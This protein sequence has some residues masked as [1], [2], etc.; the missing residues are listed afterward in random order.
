MM[1]LFVFL[2]W[3]DPALKSLTEY[4][5]LPWW[6]GDNVKLAFWRPLTSLT[7]WMDYQLWPDSPM[8]MRLQN[9]AWFMV[10]LVPGF[11]R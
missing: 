3:E 2:D 10:L 5:V 11:G 1:N 7:H 9:I 6:V 8:L 4:G